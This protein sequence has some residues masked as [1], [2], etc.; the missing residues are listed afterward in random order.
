MQL[1]CEKVGK[2]EQT[3]AN[4]TILDTNVDHKKKKN[5]GSDPSD[6]SG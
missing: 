4:L 5:C 2:V 6:I 1:E 3:I